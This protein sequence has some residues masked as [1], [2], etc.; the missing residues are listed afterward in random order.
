MQTEKKKKT[1]HEANTQTATANLY[2]L[3]ISHFLRGNS[4][5]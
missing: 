5:S 1:E 4:H 2:Y 3:Q